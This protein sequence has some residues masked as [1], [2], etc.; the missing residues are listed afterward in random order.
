MTT[1]EE[2]LVIVEICGNYAK[3]T[4]NN[5]E[6]NRINPEFI[7]DF[8]IAL[9]KVL[10]SENVTYMITTGRG[11]FFSNGLQLTDERVGGDEFWIEFNAL[12]SRLVCFPILTIAML[13]GHTF[14]GGAM[15]ALSHDYR[16]M[17]STK[18][19][20]S[21]NEV[22]LNA[23][24]PHFVMALIKTKVAGDYARQKFVVN[25]TRLVSSEAI[26]LGIVH[27]D[28][29]AEDLERTV[30]DFAQQRTKKINASHRWIT[31]RIKLDL[32]DDLVKQKNIVGNT[33][34]EEL[35]SKL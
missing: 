4:L 25:A 35:E 27:A 9:D 31:H 6:D 24:L 19:W 20:I 12:V 1:G 17:N 16:I 15:L 10:E 3:L 5:G 18:G 32:Y 33:D 11:R 21:F 23:R 8:N 7:R 22:F 28:A 26:K 29:K 34:N 14:A 2:R 30:H 13:N